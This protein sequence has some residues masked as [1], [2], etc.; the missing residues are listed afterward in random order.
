[1]VITMHKIANGDI[2]EISIFGKK[3]FVIAK[4]VKS[5][6]GQLA[7][8]GRRAA[9]VDF[10]KYIDKF[11]GNAINNPELLAIYNI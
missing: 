7:L 4:P 6:S 10:E 2:F 1:M 11:L 3:E 5:I 8:W 9:Y